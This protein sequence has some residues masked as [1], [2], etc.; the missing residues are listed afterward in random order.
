M[1]LIKDTLLL[2]KSKKRQKEEEEE[3]AALVQIQTRNLL[4][5]MRV[6]NRCA[7]NA[8]QVDLTYYMVELTGYFPFGR[9]RNFEESKTEDKFKFK[10]W[11]LI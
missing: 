8:A 5:E 10:F 11:L 3:S 7:T 4:F 9:I 2:N 1:E 6:L